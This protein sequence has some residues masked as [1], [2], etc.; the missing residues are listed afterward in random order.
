MWKK[1][2][3][4]SL[5]SS[6][7]SNDE[8]LTLGDLSIKDDEEQILE[9]FPSDTDS[10]IFPPQKRVDG[11]FPGLANTGRPCTLETNHYTLG[12]K[13]PEGVVYMYEIEIIPPWVRKYR[14]SDRKLYHSVVAAWKKTCPAVMNEQKSWVFDGCK[15]L[16]STKNHRDEEFQRMSLTVYS[17][18]EERDLNMIIKGVSKVMD[19][20]VNNDILH[21]ASKGRS[22]QIPQDSIEALNVILKHAASHDL[23]LTIIGRSFFNPGG[24]T[25]DL[26][27]GKEVWTGIFSS[28]RPQG[29]KDHGV[30]LTLNVDTS[31]KPAIQP[32]KLTGNDGYVCQVLSGKRDG[33]VNLHSGLTDYQIKVLSRDMEQ[34]KL[35]YEVPCASGQVR[36]RQ[37]KVLEVRK[38]PAN[39]EMINVDGDQLSV[40]EYFKSQYGVHLRYPN[41]PCLW[42]GSKDKTT[43]IPME[44]CTMMSQPLP[45]KKKLQDDA[46]ANMIRKTAI[47]PLE[48]QEKI[49]NGLKLNN[50]AYKN[51]PYAKEFGISLAGTMTKLTGR[52]LDP[53]SIS[54]QETA[55]NNGVVKISEQNPGKWFMESPSAK[56]KYVDGVE[57]KNWGFLN[58]AQLTEDQCREIQSNFLNIGRENG[59]MFA[60]GNNV[61]TVKCNMKDQDEGLQRIEG[62]L[63]KLK[64][65][66]VDKGR[67][68]DLVIIV[69]PFKAGIL[70][71]KI[72]CLGELKLNVTT[73]C[74]LKQSLYKKEELSRQVI[75]NI[76]LKINSKL[77]G[78]N[79]VLAKPCRPNIFKRPVMIMGADV[80]HPAPE[81]RGIKP[82]IAAVVASVDP[83]AVSYEVEVRFV[84]LYFLLF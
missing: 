80:S 29:W 28:V 61:L 66:Y 30:L 65:R 42:V 34:L 51:D 54:Y 40:V 57:V 11:S 13:I 60:T 8:G 44:F 12:V 33:K 23:G 79:H 39:K 69:L 14:S 58:L 2:R 35:K 47:K 67:Q 21:W 36:K 81:S 22:G 19:I 78:I 76:C 73:Q 83:K 4:I 43:Y 84:H 82:S 27:F 15:M 16:Y 37:Y 7:A 31:N 17:E 10:G 70:Y 52:V 20:N 74:V 25:L 1:P 41:L 3:D 72:K 5:S 63:E 46:V 71:D 50:A 18:E 53:P 77:G 24:T 64:A 55:K 56:H 45:R 38:L 62:L 75:A 49:K 26:G 48:R 9:T 59:L 32:L 68:L 6:E